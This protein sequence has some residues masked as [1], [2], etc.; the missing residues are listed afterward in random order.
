MKLVFAGT[1]A[2]IYWD[3][4]IQ[5]CY[6]LSWL[7]KLSTDLSW[8]ILLDQTSTLSLS[9]H[10]PVF[11]TPKSQVNVATTKEKWLMNDG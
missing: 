2:G 5:E 4:D 6:K 3:N 8:D 9:Q 7:T 10:S 1:D 11:P